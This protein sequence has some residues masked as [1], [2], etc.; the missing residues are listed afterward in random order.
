MVVAADGTI[1]DGADLPVV[2]RESLGMRI[3][4]VGDRIAVDLTRGISTP[5]GKVLIPAGTSIHGTITDIARPATRGNQV[6]V[7]VVFD[8][9][10]SE[11]RS[12]PIEVRVSEVSAG[13]GA[14]ARLAQRYLHGTRPLGGV[15]DAEDAIAL[16]G[17]DAGQPGKSVISLGIGDVEPILPG[18]TSLSLRLQRELALR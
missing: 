18:G 8:E 16:T 6:A 11:G 15:L 5:D 4:G 10:V 1:P 14:S 12:V 13:T 2:L 9:L 17:I 3:N 7:G